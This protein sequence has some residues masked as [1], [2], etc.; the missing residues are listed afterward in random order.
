MVCRF[1]SWAHIGF[2]WF[3][4]LLQDFTGLGFSVGV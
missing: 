2:I 4:R 1:R 3:A